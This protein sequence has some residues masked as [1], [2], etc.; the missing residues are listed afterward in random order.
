MKRV[1]RWMA[2]VL[3]ALMVVSMLPVRAKAAG[4]FDTAIKME[5][6]EFFSE[7][8]GGKHNPVTNYYAIT[9]S[10]AGTVTLYC[11]A[12][13]SIYLS[14]ESCRL[15][16]RIMDANGVLIQEGELRDNQRSEI[17]GLKKGTY[18]ISVYVQG[19]VESYTD[20]YYTFTP[21]ETPTVSYSI[22]VV[23]GTKIQ[24]G[25]VIE[26][27][28][29]KAKWTSSK[30]TVAT[31]SSKGLVTTKKAGTAYIKATLPTGE[32]AEIK[33]RVKN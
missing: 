33:I 2:V 5:P 8:F 9:L 13:N 17:V 22:T 3:T 18:Y 31:V 19:K 32:Y 24:L 12:V 15:D 16:W 23:K 28:T 29:D 14:Y 6:L 27:S 10:K 7:D 26:N 1:K 25:A 11:T 20:L 30:K 4:M 21:D